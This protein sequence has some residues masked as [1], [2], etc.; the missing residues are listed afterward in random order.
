MQQKAEKSIPIHHSCI[1]NIQHSEIQYVF[2][3][4]VIYIFG[5]L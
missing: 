5:A 4:N 2:E 3:V 1:K